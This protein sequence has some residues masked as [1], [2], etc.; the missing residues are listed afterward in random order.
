MENGND[1]NASFGVPRGELVPFVETAG[2]LAEIAKLTQE[3]RDYI[4]DAKAKNTIRAYTSDWKDFTDWCKLQRRES[5]PA[6]SETVALYITHLARG[7][8][9]STI[10]RRISS[11]SQAHAAAGYD[12]SPTKTAI[13]RATW[14]GIRRSKGVAAQGKAPVLM[15]DLRAMMEHLPKEVVDVKKA[16]KET[17]TQEGASLAYSA[18]EKLKLPQDEKE[19]EE[20]GENEEPRDRLIA[21]R[22]RAL[23]L[24]GFAGAMRRSE[25]VGLDVAD[26]VEAADG[27]VVTIRRSKTDQEGQGR[28]IGIPYGSKLATCPVR[29]LRAWKVRAKITEGPLFRQVNRHGKV[30]EGRLGDRT[31]ALVV[32][33]AVAATGVDAASYAGHSLRAGLATAAAMAGVS[34]RV[35]QGQTG[36]KSLPILRRYIRE[37]SLFRENAAAEVGL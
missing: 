13:V 15:P 6:S 17:K 34:E 18:P 16:A 31:V 29:S 23:L 2:E 21:C 19:P 7:L 37:G 27:L 32:K 9:T 5:L 8:K 24:L 35:I 25:L 11:I 14:Q 30:L 4:Q 26:V 10:Q 3:A 28:K 12:D 20:A 1:E 36:H 22:D 33:R